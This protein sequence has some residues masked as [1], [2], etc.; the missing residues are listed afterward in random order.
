L[1]A[2]DLARP[3]PPPEYPSNKW[4]IFLLVGFFPAAIIWA[5]MAGIWVIL[6]A[7]AVHVDVKYLHAGNDQRGG[8][9]SVTWSPIFWALLVFI[10]WI[11]GMLFYL[12]RRRQIW[13]TYRDYRI[14]VD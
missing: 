8:L 14:E 7:I 6:S 11:V 1:V 13:E 12:F 10:W 3:A 4:L 9:G 2:T 5:P